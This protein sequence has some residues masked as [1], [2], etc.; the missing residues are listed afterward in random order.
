MNLKESN[1]LE[2]SFKKSHL[3]LQVAITLM[4]AVLVFGSTCYA[5][6]PIVQTIYTA[7]P[8]PMIYNNTFYMFTGHD[9]D[10]S[11]WFNMKDWRCFSIYIITVKTSNKTITLKGSFF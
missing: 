10:G 4:A 7:D 6:N 1:F 9:E 3:R 8:A 11:G 2:N 5:D